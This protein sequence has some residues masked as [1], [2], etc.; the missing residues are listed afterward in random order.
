MGPDA[1]IL[2][3][4]MLSF[5]PTFSPFFF[6]FTKRLFSFTF[7]H[8]FGII[9]IS[10]FI[11]ISPGN[12]ESSLSF[13]KPGISCKSKPQWGTITRQSERLLSKSLQAKNAGEGVE[14]REPP[15]L[16]HCWWECKL[17]QPLWR[18]VG[19][20]LKTRNK[21]AIWPSNPTPGHT[22]QGNQL[23]KR[24]MYPNVHCSTVYNSQDMETT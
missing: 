7:C 3:F 23:W 13:I 10:E 16:L 1:M 18:T 5:R 2:V 15:Y 12:L 9:C 11:D 17:V 22:H 20:P 4:W 8:K 19:I 14:K 24:H 21:T 6:T